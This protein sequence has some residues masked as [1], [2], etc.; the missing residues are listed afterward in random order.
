MLRMHTATDAAT[1]IITCYVIYTGA[2]Q[3]G[4]IQL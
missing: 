1:V 4:V 2:Q 3:T